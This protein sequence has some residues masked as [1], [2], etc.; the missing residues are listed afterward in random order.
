[1]PCSAMIIIRHP[2]I[3]SCLNSFFLAV[4][5][6]AGINCFREVFKREKNNILY[7]A[8]HRI[9]NIFELSELI[10]S[11]CRLRMEKI[12]AAESLQRVSMMI[13]FLS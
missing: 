5:L 7:E 2:V 8:N 12:F 11:K 3:L 13:L 10:S 9:D 6:S 1:M 4:M